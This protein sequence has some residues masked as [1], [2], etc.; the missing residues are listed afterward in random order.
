[1]PSDFGL[2]SVFFDGGLV[3][4]FFLESTFFSSDDF[5]FSVEELLFFLSGVDLSPFEDELFFSDLLGVEELPFF[6]VLL[7]SVDLSPFGVEE[8]FFVLSLGLGVEGVFVSLLD[9]FVV[10]SDVFLGVDEVFSLEGFVFDEDSFLSESFVEELFF[11]EVDLLGVEEGLSLEVFFSGAGAIFV[12]AFLVGSF[13][14]CCLTARPSDFKGLGFSFKCF[15]T[16]GSFSYARYS[17][18]GHLESTSTAD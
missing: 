11:K 3:L 9:F 18:F 7:L 17:G 16:A 5:P 13:G 8:D 6:S 14:V 12:G 10:S 4:S 15:L 1:M 2:L